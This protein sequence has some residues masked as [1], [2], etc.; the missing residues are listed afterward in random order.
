MKKTNNALIS[1]EKEISQVYRN[2]IRAIMSTKKIT[3]DRVFLEQLTL[4]ITSEYV[5]NMEVIEMLPISVNDLWNLTKRL[6]MYMEFKAYLFNKKPEKKIY[7]IET[8][9]GK[10]KSIVLK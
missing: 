1:G 7:L 3:S 6:G 8:N 10:D 2:A 9:R 4:F 5:M